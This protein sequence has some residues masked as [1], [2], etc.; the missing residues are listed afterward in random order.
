[1][2]RRG[3]ETRE[4]EP[5][6]PTKELDEKRSVR[7]TDQTTKLVLGPDLPLL[8]RRA[9]QSNHQHDDDTE[10]SHHVLPRAPSPQDLAHAESEGRL[11]ACE[12]LRRVKLQNHDFTN[13]S[14]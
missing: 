5:A 9:S 13:S 10:R 11:D 4:M 2:G 8:V 14:P 3:K 6:H 1:M 7:T 12:A